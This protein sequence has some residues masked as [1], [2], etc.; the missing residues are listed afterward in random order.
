MLLV[1]GLGLAFYTH[2]SVHTCE[3]QA[4]THSISRLL[5]RFPFL[6]RLPYRLFRGIQPRYTIGV[7][8]VVLGPAGRILIVEHTYHP[9]FPWGFPGGWIGADEAPEIAVLRELKEEL[10]L[11][12]RVLRILHVSKTLPNHIDLAYLCEA[13]GAVGALSHELLGYR[14]ATPA[15]L[16]PLKPFHQRA[17]KAALEQFSGSALWARA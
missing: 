11:E 4:V 8:A 17:I 13:R 2:N 9:Q 10:Q 7:A 5:R 14:W 6:M 3:A 16:P 12:A 1:D 15:E